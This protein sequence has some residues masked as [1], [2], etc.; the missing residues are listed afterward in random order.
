MDVPRK[1]SPP[2]DRRPRILLLRLS[3]LGDVILTLPVLCALRKAFP[4][5]WISWV[6]EPGPARI[7]SD[8]AD[9]DEVIVVPKRWMVRPTVILKLRAVLRSRHFDWAI[10]V[11][12]LTKSAALGRLAGV[13]RQVTFATRDAR[14][15]SPLLATD[16]VYPSRG[17]VV[18]RN[19][20]LVQVLGVRQAQVEFRI[21]CWPETAEEV[22]RVR[23]QLGCS[24][25]F[26]IINPGA[27][28]PSKL[29]PAER[30]AAVA[31]HL[32]TRWKLPTLVLW[33]GEEERRLADKVVGASQGAAL[34]APPTGIRELAELARQAAIFVSGDTGPLHLAAAVGTPC[35]GLYGPWPAER[36]GPYGHQHI[37]VQKMYLDGPSRLRR[38]ASSQYMEAIDVASVCQACDQILSRTLGASAAA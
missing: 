37:W 26:G 22:F 15:L 8:H 19:L 31:T 28:W 6:V 4:A 38:K 36:C 27:G 11:Q 16:L 30:F 23:S 34:L 2:P 13:R 3:A 18:E 1:F 9:L 24:G 7:L 20:E 29:W 25:P 33:G 12:G 17:H 21:P 32:R 35:V 5:A 14:E 10:D